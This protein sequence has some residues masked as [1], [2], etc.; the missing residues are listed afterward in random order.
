M[1]PQRLGPDHIGFKV[2]SIEALKENQEDLTG[3]NPLM[4]SRPLGF[5]DEGKARLSLFQSVPLNSYHL[6]DIEGVYIGV[7]EG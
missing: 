1:D 4:R 5:G 6:T 7:S 3:Q 2:E